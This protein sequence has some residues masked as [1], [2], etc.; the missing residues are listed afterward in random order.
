[1]SCIIFE[2]NISIIASLEK[3]RNDQLTSAWL[4]IPIEKAYVIP[5]ASELGKKINYIKL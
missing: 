3:W 5:I 1:L 4:W 2:K